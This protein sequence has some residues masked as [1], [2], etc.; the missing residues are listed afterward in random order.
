MIGSCEHGNESLDS[1]KREKFLDQLT[2]SQFLEDPSPFDLI[3]YCRSLLNS[4]PW[5]VLS[6]LL[7]INRPSDLLK[8]R[9]MSTSEFKNFV[10][11]NVGAQL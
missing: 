5:C 1:V 3:C 10:A 9:N 2:Y 4:C 11:L 7:P 6:K 8:N